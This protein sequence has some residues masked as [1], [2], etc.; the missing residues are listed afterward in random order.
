MEQLKPAQPD[1]WFRWQYFFRLPDWIQHQLVEDNVSVRELVARVDEL[2]QKAPARAAVAKA[3]A[4]EIAAMAQGQQA[5]PH[6][7]KK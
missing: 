6:W 7:P 2:H 5:K 4:A 1:L 3:P